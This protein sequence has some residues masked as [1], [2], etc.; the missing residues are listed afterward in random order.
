MNVVRLDANDLRILYDHA[1][2][3]A[4]L[5]VSH[6]LR[7]YLHAAQ[8]ASNPALR[9]LMLTSIDRS[10]TEIDKMA[11]VVQEL[12]QAPLHHQLLKD[13]GAREWV[14]LTDPSICSKR[15][16]DLAIVVSA[17]TI[18]KYLDARYTAMIEISTKLESG[19]RRD[20]FA[21][22]RDAVKASE[23]SLMDMQRS[24]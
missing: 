20:D 10:R 8:T 19:V 16:R 22:S 13:Y 7:F 1:L 12:G 4:M 21:G 3:D 14:H 11:A 9:T 18:C 15:V 23:H 2:R 6:A 17:I 24:L 5:A